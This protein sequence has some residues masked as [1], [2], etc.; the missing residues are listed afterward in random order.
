MTNV[1]ITLELPK[2][3]S[4]WGPQCSVLQGRQPGL[5]LQPNT[6]H[7]SQ[8]Y[9]TISG[10]VGLSLLSPSSVQGLSG[11]D[12]WITCRIGHQT[13]R[14]MHQNYYFISKHNLLCS[15]LYGKCRSKI[16]WEDK[17]IMLLESSW[18]LLRSR[19][20]IPF[21]HRHKRTIPWPRYMHYW[22]ICFSQLQFQLRRLPLFSQPWGLDSICINRTKQGGVMPFCSHVCF[23]PFGFVLTTYRM[24]ERSH[25]VAI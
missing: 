8:L 16:Y 25:I 19:P 24:N 13:E 5:P 18:R 10:R 9:A 22:Y 23:Y 20:A 15:G 14:I 4:G 17:E 6:L 21:H 12:Y 3:R 1:F 2:W 11:K 7:S